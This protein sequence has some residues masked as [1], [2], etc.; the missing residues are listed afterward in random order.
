MFW[1]LELLHPLLDENSQGTPILSGPPA[2]SARWIEASVAQLFEVMIGVA[3]E[4]DESVRALPNE[5][6]EPS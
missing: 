4:R 5:I 3:D 2:R 6:S 1:D